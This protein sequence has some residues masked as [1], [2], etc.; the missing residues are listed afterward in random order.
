MSQGKQDP[1]NGRGPAGARKKTRGVSGMILGLSL[2]DR[3]KGTPNA[4]RS[5]VTQEST[6]PKEEDHP[7]LEAQ[8][9]LERSEK[10][11]EVAHPGMAHW[12]RGMVRQYF[13]GLRENAES[14]ETAAA[15]TPR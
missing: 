3:V 15:A 5:K 8:L 7:A 11:G 12:M 2:P 13:L 4:G 6:R 1:A 9:R 14:H 10:I